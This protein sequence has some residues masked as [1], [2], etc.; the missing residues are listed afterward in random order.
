MQIQ[1]N[2]QFAG[3][4]VTRYNWRPVPACLSYIVEDDR[5]RLPGN[6]AGVKFDFPIGDVVENEDSIVI[7]LIVP[8]GMEGRENVFA[9]DHSGNL[10]WCI[11]VEAFEAS[12]GPYVT[13]SLHRS[14]VS[15]YTKDGKVDR[16]NA[17]DGS[18][19][20]QKHA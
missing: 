1:R 3:S 8:A 6:P 11:A 2:H 12:H 20:L 7:W 10:R 15:L 14:V 17:S 4:H 5:I 18:K 13:L 19:I 9:I 16:V